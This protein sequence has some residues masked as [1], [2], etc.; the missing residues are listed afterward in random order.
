MTTCKVCKNIVS[1]I[2]DN[3][4][5]DIMDQMILGRQIPLGGMLTNILLPESSMDL[6]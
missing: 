3:A 1:N 5:S 6:Q 4:D 2:S